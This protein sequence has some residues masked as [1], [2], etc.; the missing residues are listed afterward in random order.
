V[1]PAAEVR[2]IEVSLM[3]RP[4]YLL[5]ALLSF[6]VIT[7]LPR[8]AR[9]A[10]PR[11]EQLAQAL[12]EEGR[13]LMD[14]RRYAEACPKLKESQRLDPGGGT[15]LNLAICH[16]KE[17]KLATAKADYEEALAIA[18]RD[19]RKDRQ[20]IARARLTA[21]EPTVPRLR[22]SVVSAADTPGLEIKLDGLVLRRAAWGVATP[23]DP[24][25]HRLEASASG[26]A[27]WSM[28]IT[29]QPSQKKSIEVPALGP[30]TELP[31]GGFAGGSVVGAG[32]GAASG[33]GLGGL[34]V[35]TPAP[36]PEVEAPMIVEE[37]SPPPGDARVIGDV[38]PARSNP[39][40]YGALG[41]ALAGATTSAITGFVAFG[42]QRDAKTG[43]L[44]DRSY[45]R[46][47]ASTDAADR[48]TTMA[49][50]STVS[51]GVAVVGV[52]G[53]LALPRRLGR[54]RAALSSPSPVLSPSPSLAPTPS[55]PPALLSPS[56]SLGA[57][58]GVSKV[59]G[60]ASVSLSGTF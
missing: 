14:K 17:G 36:A 11:E 13:A 51:L 40:F 2:L 37:G 27:A 24:G 42:A 10:D 5:V 46:D 52:I 15:L 35:A 23:V 16:E 45:C 50:V 57:S 38:Q 32:P 3:S 54:E 26:R 59:P 30:L 58:L 25:P 12:F 34:G 39:L 31:G 7:S 44:P 41:L 19:A 22:V 4:P 1:R 47:Q 9:A 28:P 6:E 33:P 53:M 8:A 56:P 21:L 18:M 55:P 48:A 29:L 20:A 60:G 49:W 43:C